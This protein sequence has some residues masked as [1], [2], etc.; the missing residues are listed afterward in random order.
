M[1][2]E[3]ETVLRRRFLLLHNPNAGPRGRTI[4]DQVV[5]K[6][7]AR[8]ASVTRGP[9][10]PT[11]TAED[12]PRLSEA[13]DAVL[14]AGGDGTIRVVARLFASSGLPLG[15]IPQG[16]GNVFAHEIALPKS[17]DAL[18]SVL[19]SGPV[20]SVKGAMANGLPFFLMAGAG[21][22]G[23]VIQR[24]SYTGK[25]MLGKAAYVEPVIRALGVRSKPLD[26][27]ID[28][29]SHIAH[30]IIVANAAYYA[31]GFHLSDA[32]GITKDGLLCIL[33]KGRGRIA[34]VRH[35]VSLGLG[36]LAASRSVDILP[37]RSVSIRS[38]EP[39]AIEVDG[40][41]AG[42]TPLDIVWGQ[43]EINL[44]VPRR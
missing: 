25:R 39:V 8:G 18:A 33:F 22:D 11:V 41:K 19:V 27:I 7:E 37:A 12:V 35:L 28:G 24:L 1:P 23:E 2:S 21:F 42:V 30:W 6:L 10:L 14:A 38:D 17:A 40:D 29:Q 3:G 5:S 34:T 36:R 26:C 15:I 44:I 16:T 4:V 9:A 13:C 43:P 20:T 31:G 32:A